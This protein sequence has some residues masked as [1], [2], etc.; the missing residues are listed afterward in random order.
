MLQHF[1]DAIAQVNHREL[2]EP[3]KRIIGCEFCKEGAQFAAVYSVMK[4]G[5]ESS[6]SVH[7]CG[8]REC[9]SRAAQSAVA[10]GWMYKRARILFHIFKILIE[11]GFIEEEN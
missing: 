1:H 4:G 8:S 11:F 7:H 9:V 6:F 10:L 3:Y 5:V 2:E